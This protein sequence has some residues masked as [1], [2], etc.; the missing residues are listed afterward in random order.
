M[1]YTRAVC[2]LHSSSKW[3]RSLL[4]RFLSLRYLVAANEPGPSQLPSTLV[5]S[6][7]LSQRRVVPAIGKD[8]LQSTICMQDMH[9]VYSC[10]GKFVAL[11]K[12][13][14]KMPCWLGGGV[15]A[16]GGVC[17]HRMI[18][19]V[20]LPSPVHG[21]S[22]TRFPARVSFATLS[23]PLDDTTQPTHYDI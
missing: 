10:L 8:F 5:V 4:D 16:I 18:Y 9:S 14:C 11:S 15:S 6:I 7:K 17:V 1:F 13:I 19:D 22:R 12:T 21:P 3:T 20:S 23:L 2:Q